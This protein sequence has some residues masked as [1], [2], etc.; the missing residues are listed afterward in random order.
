MLERIVGRIRRNLVAIVI[1]IVALGG[2]T[3]AVAANGPGSSSGS[4]RIYAC[5]TQAFR[6]LNLS[7]ASARCP[8]GQRKISW[9]ATGRKGARGARGATGAAGAAGAQG[10][11]GATGAQGATGAAGPQGAQGLDGA[12]GP[13]GPMGLVG[14]QGVQGIPGLIGPQGIQGLTGAIG[15]Q[16]PQGDPGPQGVPGPVGPAGP[17][18]EQ[19]EQGDAGPTGPQGDPGAV[20]PQGPEGDAG[21]EG[22]E[23]PVGAVGPAG[24]TGP[25]GAQQVMQTEHA[26]QEIAANAAR[27]TLTTW[28]APSVETLSGFDEATGEFTAPSAGTYRVAYEATAGPQAAV[29]ISTGASTWFSLTLTRNGSDLFERRFPVLDV[30]VALVLTL[31]TPLREASVSADRYVTMDAGD[32]LG[33]DVTNGFAIKMDLT[34][35]LS[36]TK[37]S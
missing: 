19:G 13:I 22:P 34:A 25:S 14:P 7:S 12:A 24:P 3:L 37:V 28:D 10:T 1:A 8:E 15:P 5:V 26:I 11:P 36:I 21:P 32:V 30:N 6:T 29:S 35:A 16:G 17:Q 23:G 33:L 9:S 27:A 20:G 18:G 4:S 2:T 31:R